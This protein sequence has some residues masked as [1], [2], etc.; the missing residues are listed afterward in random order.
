MKERTDNAASHW[1]LLR[2]DALSCARAFPSESFDLLYA[3]PPFFT[4]RSHR[5]LEGGSFPDRRAGGMEGYLAWLEPRMVEMRRLLAPSGSLF[6]HLDW[7]A[8][9]A[10]KLLL[11]RIFGPRRFVNE[12][13]WAYRTGGTSG[14]RLARK[15]DTIFFYSRSA[16]YKFHPLRERSDLRHDYGFANANVQRD[17]RGPFR[18]T[19]MRDVWEIPALRGNMPERVA[20]PTQKPLAL[21]RRIVRLASDPGDLIGDFFCGSGTTVAAALL[22]RRKGVG[23]DVEPGALRIATARL[24]AI[25]PRLL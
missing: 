18:M 3:D 16:E 22:E 8:S 25:E 1:M 20:Y 17:E 13:V 9:H 6:V 21:L 23:A 19:L 12:I 2:G 11:D 7:H 15:H 24:H 4:G 10:V 14:R 5:V